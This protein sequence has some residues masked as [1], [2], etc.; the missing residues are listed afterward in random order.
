MVYLEEESTDEKEYIDS[1]NP[2]GIE[3]VT[4]EFIICLARAVKV[5]Q[6]AEKCCYHCGSPDHFICV[7]PLLV[8]TQADP[9]FNGREGTAPR[10]GA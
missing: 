9:P 10:K 4:E 5:T 1:N 6:W 2:D 7:C 8:G 3:G